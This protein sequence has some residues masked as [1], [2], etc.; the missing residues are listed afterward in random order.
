M[1][2]EKLMIDNHDTN[3]V[4][5]ITVDDNNTFVPIIHPGFSIRTEDLWSH[6]NNSRNREESNGRFIIPRNCRYHQFQEH[7]CSLIIEDEPRV[8]AI[9]ISSGDIAG[10]VERYKS[11]PFHKEIPV[12]EI[13]WRD[14]DG[15]WNMNIVL[16]YVIYGMQFYHDHDNNKW[17]KSRFSVSW[18]SEPMESMTDNVCWPCLYNIS[19]ELEVCMGDSIRPQRDLGHMIED[20]ISDFWYR[21][22]NTDYS[23]HYNLYRGIIPELSSWVMYA[24]NT[25]IDPRFILNV[26]LQPAMQIENIIG[27]IHID[28]SNKGLINTI[29]DFIASPPELRTSLGTFYPTNKKEIVLRDPSSRSRYAP[30]SVLVIGEEITMG[31]HTRYVKRFFTSR[32]SYRPDKVLMED[33]S[34]KEVSYRLT[35]RMME[36]LYKKMNEK[37][38]EYEINGHTYHVGDIISYMIKDY[39]TFPIYRK[40]VSITFDR[41]KNALF[42]LGNEFYFIDHLV[43]E[44]F[45]V[46]EDF[47]GKKLVEGT[48]Y[49]IVSNG[50][51]HAT[52]TYWSGTYVN[53]QFDENAS[54]FRLLFAY[55]GDMDD[56]STVSEK[57]IKIME[58][59]E[60]SGDVVRPDIFSSYGAMFS[61]ESSYPIYIETSSPTM[62]IHNND[63]ECQSLRTPY[64]WIANCQTK[65]EVEY[66]SRLQGLV[67]FKKGDIVA[68]M[69]W[70]MSPEN[71]TKLWM[72]KEFVGE[73]DN[74]IDVILES[75]SE[76]IR[77]PYVE[78]HMVYE[79]MLFHASI[80]YDDWEVGDIVSPLVPR[81]NKFPKK[82]KYKI[83]GFIHTGG[84]SPIVMFNNC[85]TQWAHHLDIDFVKSTTRKEIEL[86]D[87]TKW[88]EG[89]MLFIHNE[90]TTNRYCVVNGRIDN[91]QY[92]FIDHWAHARDYYGNDISRISNYD[93]YMRCGVPLPRRS[94]KQRNTDR[95]NFIINTCI[96]PQTR[97][98]TRA[99][100]S[101]SRSI[102]G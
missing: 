21:K 79:H 92:N 64:F 3:F 82:N 53:F 86:Y 98:E 27:K 58:F 85:C 99:M 41:N 60:E 37:T 94:V 45:D 4:K 77:L 34:G 83:M 52:M 67:H 25:Q 39:N 36:Y 95:G 68:C 7:Y 73:S 93:F 96:E 91:L 18:R 101:M 15:Y 84:K 16:P 47:I 88:Q 35:I 23:Q 71:L 6:I 54:E 26:D 19:E 10:D 42:K 65:Q 33:E 50:R 17:E 66:H 44:P 20:T 63:T 72:I 90:N 76:R 22:F 29:R 43:I 48:S 49:K 55:E 32:N 100:I 75:G 46:P 40:L 31:K 97:Y 81:M 30:S 9:K 5:G 11:T 89:D 57:D 56:I 38:T 59:M 12:D 51:K 69:D 80:K 74:N 8:R 24:Y 78:N 28:P 14:D 13:V 102:F 2:E 87:D 62:Y 70:T 61:Q 1:L